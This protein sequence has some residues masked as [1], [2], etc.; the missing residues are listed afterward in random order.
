MAQLK[1][2][3]ERVNMAKGKI[4]RLNTRKAK[5]NEIIS[6]GRPV[7]MKLGLGYIGTNRNHT[8]CVNLLHN[9]SVATQVD[10]VMAQSSKFLAALCI[11]IVLGNLVDLEESDW[12]F[13]TYQSASTSINRGTQLNVEVSHSAIL[14]RQFAREKMAIHGIEI[15]LWFNIIEDLKGFKIKQL[16]L[17]GSLES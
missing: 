8:T 7:G 2:A 5:L 6:V 16:V 12:K 9:L 15:V 17:R 1:D 13:K 11:N 14:R 4:A 3:M 10:H